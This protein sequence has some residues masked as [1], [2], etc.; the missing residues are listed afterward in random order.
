MS[1][2]KKM[3]SLVAVVICLFVMTTGSA[4]AA[5]T[6]PHTQAKALSTTAACYGHTCNDQDPYTYGCWDSNAYINSPSKYVYDSLSGNL[7]AIIENWYSPDCNANWNQ[8]ITYGLLLYNVTI[9]NQNKD[10]GCYPSNCKPI[11]QGFTSS[12][13]YSDMVDGSTKTVACIESRNYLH[14]G[15]DV[16]ISTCGNWF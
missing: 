7:V 15:S 1:L 12:P 8:T 10:E 9:T 11:Y 13:T 5:G 14:D 4:F 6:G 2:L 3:F 16:P